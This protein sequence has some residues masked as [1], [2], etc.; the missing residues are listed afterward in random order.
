MLRV[1]LQ[2]SMLDRLPPESRTETSETVAQEQAQ[3]DE[4][5]SASDRLFGFLKNT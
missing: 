1:L 2:R 3:G 4:Q 5:R